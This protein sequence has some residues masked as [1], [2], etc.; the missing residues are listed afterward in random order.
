MV[1]RRA[2]EAANEYYTAMMPLVFGC[3]AFLSWIG[4]PYFSK[5]HGVSQQPILGSQHII[6][7]RHKDAKMTLD[8][9]CPT[10]GDDVKEVV[11]SGDG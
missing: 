9:N 7:F 2:L 4:T 5:V 6:D 3:S 11:I 10:R 1:W 8:R